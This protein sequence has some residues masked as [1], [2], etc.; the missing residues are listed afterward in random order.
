VFEAWTDESL[1]GHGLRGRL[2]SGALSPANPMGPSPASITGTGNALKGTPDPIGMSSV[3]PRSLPAGPSGRI[4]VRQAA[5]WDPES[6]AV[7]ETLQAWAE[8]LRTIAGWKKDRR[9]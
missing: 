3:P 1:R 2:E 9:V 7:Q 8:R 4:Y 5:L 6:N